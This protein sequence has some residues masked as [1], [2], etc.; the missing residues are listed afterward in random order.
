MNWFRENP[1]LGRFLI[2][3][4]VCLLGTTMVFLQREGRLG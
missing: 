4:G 1:F 3:F 2:V